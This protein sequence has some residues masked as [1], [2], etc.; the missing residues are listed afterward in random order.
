MQL[1]VLHRDTVPVNLCRDTA[2]I[3]VQQGCCTH[4]RPEMQFPLTSAVTRHALV[5]VQERTIVFCPL[6][7]EHRNVNV[8]QL[9]SEPFQLSRVQLSHV[10]DS[11]PSW[12]SGL[13]TNADFLCQAVESTR[14]DCTLR[15][16]YSL[17]PA[18]ASLHPGMYD[19]ISTIC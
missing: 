18:A 9:L 12:C 3:D 11:Y 19:S 15:P 16:E 2:P 14:G 10:C 4:C 17:G 13:I 6:K 8:L 7:C 1:I 5:R